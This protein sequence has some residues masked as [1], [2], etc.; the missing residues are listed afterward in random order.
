MSSADSP[1]VGFPP[2]L[3]GERPLRLPVRHAGEGLLVLDKPSGVP[4]VPDQWY[5]EASTILAALD[6]QARAGKPELERLGVK[7]AFGLAFP[8]RETSGLC[9][10]PVSAEAS[11]FYRNQMG[12]GQ[13]TF[14]FTVL[15]AGEAEPGEERT[16]DLPLSRNRGREARMVVSHKTGK[17]AATAFRCRERVGGYSLWE[18]VTDF[19]RPHQIRLHAAECALPVVGETL[20]ADVP[21][22][23]LSKLKRGYRRKEGV[24]ER[25]LYEGL[26][27]HLSGWTFLPFTGTDEGTA[28]AVTVEA[29]LP[30]GWQT[31]LRRLAPQAFA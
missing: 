1:A 29:P 11:G 24:P 18:A 7:A 3:L 14:T 28:E 5:P 13:M 22:V 12:S 31:L 2:P 8:D 21:P 15:A 17:K 23:Y 26:C 25:P 6:E 19:P 16:C 4:A 20:Y 9:A 27:A 10:F 30:A